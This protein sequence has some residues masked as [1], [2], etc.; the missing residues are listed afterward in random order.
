MSEY[1]LLIDYRYCTGCLSCDFACNQEFGFPL[2]ESGI[3]VQQY[4][5]WE[6]EEDKYEYVFVPAVTALCNLC[7]ER[8]EK[9]KQ[10]T[11]VQHCQSLCMTYGSI[12]DLAKEMVG[13]PKQ[14]LF[15]RGF[16]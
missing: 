16:I 13:K 4:G 12:E 15:T 6:I 3:K 7:D 10:P 14:V 1:G 8:V 2:G 9:G 5:P 11:C